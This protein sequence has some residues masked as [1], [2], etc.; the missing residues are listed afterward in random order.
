LKEKVRDFEAEVRG[1]L[2]RIKGVNTRAEA[3]EGR[4]QLLIVESKGGSEGWIRRLEH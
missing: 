3:M 2:M 4:L 1:I